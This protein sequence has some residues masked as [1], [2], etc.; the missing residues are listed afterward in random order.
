MVGP[1]DTIIGLI[2][3]LCLVHKMGTSLNHMLM[4]IIMNF[5]CLKNVKVTKNQFFQRSGTVIS[6]R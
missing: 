3:G 1:L 4:G 2:K 5:I 6:K